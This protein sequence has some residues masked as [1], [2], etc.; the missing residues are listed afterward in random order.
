MYMH[1]CTYITI[2][3]IYIEYRFT[4]LNITNIDQHVV[5]KSEVREIVAVVVFVVVVVIV[6]LVVDEQ[7]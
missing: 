5:K 4:G 1:P 2:Y 3:N 6:V 7:G